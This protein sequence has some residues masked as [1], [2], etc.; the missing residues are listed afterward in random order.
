MADLN[1]V[2]HVFRKGAGGFCTRCGTGSGGDW[3]VEVAVDAA[4]DEPAVSDEKPPEIA[5]VNV[6]RLSFHPRNIRRDLGDLRDLT[7]SIQKEGVLQPILVHRVAGG[8][9]LVDGH[10]RVAAARIGN[11][12]RVPAVILASQS[13]DQV[14]TKALATGLLKQ[15]ISKDER[16]VAVRALMHEFKHTAAEIGEALGVAESTVYA[17]AKIPREVS[18]RPGK[19]SFPKLVAVAKVRAVLDYWRD[20]VAPGVAALIKDIEALLPDEAGG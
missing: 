2:A 3:H 13:E 5:M 19:K 14:I 7:R 16:R 6:A 4:S 11:V 15:D 18:G 10:R 1:I 17:W 12:K 8:L 9:Q 20:D